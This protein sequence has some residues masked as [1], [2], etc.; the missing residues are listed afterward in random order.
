MRTLVFF[1]FL[2]PFIV[3][4]QELSIRNNDKGVFYEVTGEIADKVPDESLGYG[5]Y[6]EYDSYHVWFVE[7][8]GED[9]F[10]MLQDLG[11]LQFNIA[12]PHIDAEFIGDTLEFGS[13]MPYRSTMVVFRYLWDNGN[14]IELEGYR[15]DIS[16]ELVDEADSLLL[17]G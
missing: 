1:L 3:H 10:N 2:L 4:G 6:A 13:Q 16:Q 11:E 12:K 9:S 8:T 7:R 17:E 15:E 14:L 5:I